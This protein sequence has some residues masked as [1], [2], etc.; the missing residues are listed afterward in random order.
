VTPQELEG[1]SV[2]ALGALAAL[3]AA[4]VVWAFTRAMAAVSNRP[5]A[6][7]VVV[8]VALLTLAAMGLF[9]VTGSDQAAVLAGTGMG[10]LAGAVTSLYGGGND[11]TG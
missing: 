6:T 7:L 5:P 10:A 8:L 11:A 9:L 4:V 1:L 3:A 2:L